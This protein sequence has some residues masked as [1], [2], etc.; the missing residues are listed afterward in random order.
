MDLRSLSSVR[1][2]R[3]LV[4]GGDQRWDWHIGVDSVPGTEFLQ[5]TNQGVMT[6]FKKWSCSFNIPVGFRCL[7][8][9]PCGQWSQGDKPEE[10]S[11]AD[12]WWVLRI[13]RGSFQTLE[14]LDQDFRA[15][16]GRTQVPE[17][18]KLPRGYPRAVRAGNPRSRRVSFIF[19]V[20]K[21][22][23]SHGNDSFWCYWSWSVRCDLLTPPHC[24]LRNRSI[25]SLHSFSSTIEKK[26]KNNP[27]GLLTDLSALQEWLH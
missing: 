17:F 20:G 21:Q 27:P 10:A 5:K 3:D 22:R 9:S 13:T 19:W 25:L 12:A 26:K 18:R 15:S 24:S 6:C 23:L 2:Q 1:T 14:S 7:L 16:G 8:S 11:L 4:V